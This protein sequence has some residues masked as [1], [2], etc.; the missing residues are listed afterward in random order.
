MG[1]KAAVLVGKSRSTYGCT[2]RRGLFRPAGLFRR[3]GA[4]PRPSGL[5]E[6][7]FTPQPAVTI[8]KNRLSRPGPSAAAVKITGGMVDEASRRR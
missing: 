5:F 2:R 6:A 7:N 4:G 3:A 1:G 8:V